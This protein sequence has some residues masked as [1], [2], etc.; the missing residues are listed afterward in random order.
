MMRTDIPGIGSNLETASFELSVPTLDPTDLGGS[1]GSISFT[2]GPIALPQKLRNSRFTMTDDQYG[3]VTGRISQISWGNPGQVSF[4]AET[5]LQRLNIQATILPAYLVSMADAINSALGHA[6]MVCAGLP[7]AGLVAFPGYAGTV[8]DYVKFFCTVYGYEVYPTPGSPNVITF[9]AI[10]GAE[11]SGDW[12]SQT[13]DVNDQT[14]AK[15]VDV[16]RYEYEVPATSAANIEFTPAGTRDAQIL[17]VDANQVISYDIRLDGWAQSVNQPVVADLIGPEE[18]TDVGAYCVAGSDGLPISAAQWS[19]TG[20]SVRVEITDDPAVL[21][22]TITGP[23]ADV[24]VSADGTTDRFAPYSLAATTGTTTYNSL[25]ITGKGIRARATTQTF[26]TGAVSEV[27]MEET[28][29]TVENPFVNTIALLWNVGVRAAQVYAGSRHTQSA[30]GS[31]DS[32]IIGV[33]GSRTSDGSAKFRVETVTVSPD[34]VSF[35]AT[36][37]TLFSDFNGVWAGATFNDFRKSRTG[38]TFSDFNADWIGRTF[39]DFDAVWA[40]QTFSDFAQVGIS[41]TFTQFAVTPLVR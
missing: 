14:V 30:S 23:K 24:I 28:G 16:V 19:N 20:G 5:M 36:A 32:D 29:S 3:S 15:S 39:G 27:S 22:V 41:D 34:L 4:S 17:T 2:T 31:P 12:S 35:S 13:F 10:R 8:L 9:R 26:L 33:L 7:T 40:G 21:R 18:R 11:Y 1:T 25:H 37:D 6:G 38:V